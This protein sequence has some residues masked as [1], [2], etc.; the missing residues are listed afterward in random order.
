LEEKINAMEGK[1]VETVIPMLSHE[2]VV[3]GYGVVMFHLEKFFRFVNLAQKNKLGW[4]SLFKFW[5]FEWDDMVRSFFWVGVLI[6]FDDDLVA[7]Y[8]SWAETDIASPTTWMYFVTGF[9]IDRLVVNLKK[10]A[11]ILDRK[12]DINLYK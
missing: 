2:Y 10:N 7:K 3:A 4:R 9:G 1:F 5:W 6:A 12:I 11:K 8:N